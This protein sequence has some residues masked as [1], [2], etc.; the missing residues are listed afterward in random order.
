MLHFF[1]FLLRFFNEFRADLHAFSSWFL[2]VVN[3][4]D[5]SCPSKKIFTSS[6]NLASLFIWSDSVISTRETEFP[7]TTL[8]TSVSFSVANATGMSVPKTDLSF[9]SVSKIEVKLF[10]VVWRHD[11]ENWTPLHFTSL[12]FTA[13]DAHVNDACKTWREILMKNTCYCNTIW[14]DGGEVVPE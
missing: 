14:G 7:I 8:H 9:S 11:I 10:S 3:W 1:V 13:W 4:A 2:A 6:R 12:H 5:I